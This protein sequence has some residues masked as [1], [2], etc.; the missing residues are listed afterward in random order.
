MNDHERF[1]M[2]VVDWHTVTPVPMCSRRNKRHDLDLWG[3]R[4]A[5]GVWFVRVLTRPPHPSAHH[6]A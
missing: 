2:S 1:S 4:M 6:E 3:L 5:F